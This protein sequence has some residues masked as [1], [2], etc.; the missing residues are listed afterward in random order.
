MSEQEKK[1]QRIYDLLHAKTKPKFLCLPYT[2][3]SKK[4]KNYRKKLYKET[5]E[6]MIEKKERKGFLIALAWTIKKDPTRSI[7]KYAYELKV[8]KKTVR[9][10]N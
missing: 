4:K 2:K 3:H 6:W 1:R 9:G 8:H 7:R 10:K 5:G